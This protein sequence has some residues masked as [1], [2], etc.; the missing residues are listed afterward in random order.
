MKTIEQVRQMKQTLIKELKML[1]EKNAFGDSNSCDRELIQG[2]IIDLAYIE[3][4]GSPPDYDSDVSLWFL[5]ESFSP[6]CD[7][8]EASQEF[9]EYE[10]LLRYAVWLNL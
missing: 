5:E 1:P 10:Q 3:N 7:Y 2:W 6:L 8:E 9:T 4:F